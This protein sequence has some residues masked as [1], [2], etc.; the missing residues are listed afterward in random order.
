MTKPAVVPGGKLLHTSAPVSRR[1]RLVLIIV[2]AAAAVSVLLVWLLYPKIGSWVVRTRVLPRVA[3]KLGRDLTVG[4]VSVGFGHVELRDIRVWGP[5]DGEGSLVTVADVG[6]DY[7]F[8]AAVRGELRLGTMVVHAPHLSLL[9]GIA[10]T[11]NF[12]DILEKLRAPGGG[13][14]PGGPSRLPARVVLKGGSARYDDQLNGVIAT[15]DDA[16]G[17]VVPRGRA[18]VTLS[19]VTGVHSLGPRF[20]VAELGLSADV[21]DVRRT[22]AISIAGGSASIWPK[23]SL[24]DIRG[25]ITADDQPGRARVALEGGYGG[26]GDTLWHAEGWV[27]PA[28]GDGEVHLRAD[29]FTLD[30]IEKILVDTPIQDP[31]H[32]SIDA[33][34]DLTLRDGDLE[35]A[36][37]V[38]LSGL[39][40]YHPWLSAETV[41]DLGG[42]GNIRGRI[43]RKARILKLDELSVRAR[44]IELRLDGEA[45]LERGLDPDGTRRGQP[46]L[47]ARLVVPAVPCQQ[48]LDAIPKEVAPRLQGFRL[49]GTFATDVA[50]K[51]DWADL[52]ALELLGSVGIFGCKVADAPADLRPEAL[53]GE[54]EHV[55]ELEENDFMSF[56][57]GPEN[58]DFVPYAEVSHYLLD[59]LI[60]TED[61]GFRKHKGFITREFKSALIKNLK[62]GY[63]KYG[64]SSITMQIAKNVFLYREKTLSRKL[65]ELFL[66]WYLET[67]LPKER[68][69]EIYVNVIEFGPGLYG[70]GP[71]AQHY[72]GK[73]ARDLNPLEAAFFSS[74]LP[75]PKKRYL[76]YCEGELN[77]WGDA[78]VARIIKLNH[79]RGLI[80]DEEYQAAIAQPLQFVRS[81]T[82]SREECVTMT[83]RM[84][85]KTRATMPKKGGG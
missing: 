72:F 15:I 84:I 56:V 79:E 19:G 17:T 25:K 22:L 75:S 43:L 37:G 2:G 61:S 67:V 76:Q 30:K 49:K 51:I 4:T 40:L 71:A 3:E 74:I 8:W 69:L 70:I 41:R 12:S 28:A 62:E 27:D 9:R 59:S 13:G 26:A 23:L 10:G 63:F 33:R 31:A 7:D 64:A 18:D 65:Q 53:N 54:F 52:D 58:P 83:K 46:R 57:V 85:Q 80:S 35:F 66:T 11:D 16:S 42:S 81:E 68:L 21:A 50:I 5:A 48:F 20:A 82:F 34:L 36:G 1:V 47:R 55:V 6:I 73:R 29:R 39:T 38:D 60:S 14:G 24:T 77:R 45:A 44:G 32:T 78:K